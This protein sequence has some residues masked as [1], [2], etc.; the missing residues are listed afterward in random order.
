MTR[1]SS[2]KRSRER[3]RTLRKR[4]SQ[5]KSQPKNQAL[6]K[7]LRRLLKR[8]LRKNEGA[9]LPMRDYMTWTKNYSKRNWTKNKRKRTSIRLSK[10][11]WITQITQHLREKSHLIKPY[12]RML[13]E[14]DMKWQRKRKNTTSWDQSQR[15]RSTIM[16][17]QISMSRR[18]SIRS[19]KLQNNK[20]LKKNNNKKKKA[21]KIKESN[22]NIMKSNKKKIRI[23]VLNKWL[24]F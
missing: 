7:V 2:K 19:S 22:L 8:N 5:L 23:W 15:M 4:P 17:N 9:N 20:W 14:E 6:L 12:M 21:E 3:M 1:R 10:V 16:I 11:T 24:K 13:R 18:D